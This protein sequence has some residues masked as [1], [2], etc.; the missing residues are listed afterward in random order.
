MQ[1]AP[2]PP[3]D[4]EPWE[5][6]AI[7]KIAARFFHGVVP[8]NVLLDDLL[9]E[10][11][12]HWQKVR[13]SYSS[14]AG[15]TKETYLERVVTRRLISIQR[16]WRAATRGGGVLP[17]SLQ[18]PIRDN[19][20][21]D[22]LTLGDLLIAPENQNLDLSVD[23]QRVIAQLTPREQLI[24]AGLAE[25]LDKLAIADRIGVSRD[26][27]NEDLKRIRAVCAEAGLRDYL[28]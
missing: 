6:A 16:E 24:V 27:V 14:A 4:F 9:Q 3:D 17:L 26:T 28:A 2:T 1:F 25:Q 10:A 23:L 12:T 18:R 22:E 20:S 5:T 11:F 8:P 7:E 15:A 19:D 21:S 13:A